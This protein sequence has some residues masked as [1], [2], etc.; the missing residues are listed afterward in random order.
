[1]SKPVTMFCFSSPCLRYPSNFKN[2]YYPCLIWRYWKK[3]HLHYTVQNRNKSRDNWNEILLYWDIEA[4]LQSGVDVMGG[5]HVT[6][7]TITLGLNG[8]THFNDSRP[9]CKNNG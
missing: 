5:V 6:S 3:V 2:S 1:M 8:R 4:A 7:D 9:R